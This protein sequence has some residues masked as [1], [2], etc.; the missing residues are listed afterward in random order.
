MI[1]SLFRVIEYVTGTNGYLMAHEWPLY[2]FDT[3][4]MFGVLTLFFYYHPSR[5]PG[6]VSGNLSH[7]GVTSVEEEL[8]PGTGSENNFQLLEQGAQQKY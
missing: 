7:I 1:R 3:I 5:I 6:L 2:V 4:L 8:N